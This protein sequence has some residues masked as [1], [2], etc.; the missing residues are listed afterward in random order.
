MARE[1]KSP[2][3]DWQTINLPGLVWRS[4][5]GFTLPPTTAFKADALAG[6]ANGGDEAPKVF[7]SNANNFYGTGGVAG[8]FLSLP[9]P[10]AV[11]GMPSQLAE[12]SGLNTEEMIEDAANLRGLLIECVL[13]G[14]TLIASPAV[15]DFSARAKFRGFGVTVD[16]E[17]TQDQVI[18]PNAAFP[19]LSLP[20][21]VGGGQNAALTLAGAI[22][23]ARIRTLILLPSTVALGDVVEINCDFTLAATE[24]GSVE[25]HSARYAWVT[26]PF[27]FPVNSSIQLEGQDSDAAGDPLREQLEDQS[28]LDTL[29]YEP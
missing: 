1:G 4:G 5:A 20:S 29:P 10:D 2:W 18:Q 27:P 19:D 6:Q 3:Q 7:S 28:R 24:T 23:I 12:W 14:T 21:Q 15:T 9:L 13:V 17:P 26:Q 16:G 11:V 25:W 22:S 8:W